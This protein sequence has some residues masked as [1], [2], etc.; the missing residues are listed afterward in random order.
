MVCASMSSRKLYCSKLP[1]KHFNELRD[2]QKVFASVCVV[3]I[4]LGGG[5]SFPHDDDAAAEYLFVVR[6]DDGALRSLGLSE[7][8]REMDGRVPDAHRRQPRAS[9][10]SPRSSAASTA[11]SPASTLSPLSEDELIAARCYTGLY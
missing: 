8:P 1:P 11:S 6:P 2:S 10:R 9:P 5:K 7:W 3:S 4:Q